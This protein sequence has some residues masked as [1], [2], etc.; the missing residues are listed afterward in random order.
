MPYDPRFNFR[1]VLEGSLVAKHINI[2]DV[3]Q[4]NPEALY[5]SRCF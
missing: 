4:Q 3:L 2:V 1:G 5:S